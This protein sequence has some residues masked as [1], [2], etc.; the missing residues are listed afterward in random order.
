[1][2]TLASR[3]DNPTVSDV[4]ARAWI[5]VLLQKTKTPTRVKRA[6]VFFDSAMLNQCIQLGLCRRHR[7]NGLQ[8]AA[9]DLVWVTL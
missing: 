8:N 9:C 7:R 4:E 5:A 1:L 6:G 2:T 3:H